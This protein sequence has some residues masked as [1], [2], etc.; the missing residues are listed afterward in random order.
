MSITFYAADS[1]HVSMA[2]TTDRMSACLC[3]QM[4]PCWEMYPAE[5][6]WEELQ[7]HA[8]DD[9]P[10]CGG[11]GL[12]FESTPDDFFNISNANAR[13]LLSLLAFEIEPCGTAT[14]PDVR[15]GI[16]RARATFERRAGAALAIGPGMAEQAISA[17]GARLVCPRVTTE[18]L[19]DRLERFAAFVERSSRI[20]ATHIVWG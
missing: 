1:E 6:T 9:C 4:A 13:A 17:L 20:G 19:R 18:D 16:M 5:D 10:V 2:S 12:E 3:A 7:R 8:R 14:L 15:R 11:T